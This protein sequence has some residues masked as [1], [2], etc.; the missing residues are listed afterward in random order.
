MENTVLKEF[1]SVYCDYHEHDIESL[2]E[3]KFVCRDKDDESCLLL[4]SSKLKE[5]LVKRGLYEFEIED[6]I[7]NGSM[8]TWK[9]M[10]DKMK[11]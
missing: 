1:L 8:T 10:A 4:M 11:H 5:Y 6:F 3:S 9:I 7:I 2:I